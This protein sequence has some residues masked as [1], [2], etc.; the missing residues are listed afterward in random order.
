MNSLITNNEVEEVR[1][2]VVT[3]YNPNRVLYSILHL[4]II[5]EDKVTTQFRPV[6]D[7]SAKNIQGL[8]LNDQLIAGPKTQ[9]F[10]SLLKIDVRLNT[11]VLLTDLRRVFHSMC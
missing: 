1:D 9:S 4:S 11:I 5:G 10:L 3:A 6:L 8:S 2:N 7:V